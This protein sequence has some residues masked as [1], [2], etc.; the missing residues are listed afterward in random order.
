M[1]LVNGFFTVR[2]Q[3]LILWFAALEKLKRLLLMVAMIACI[4]YRPYYLFQ[5]PLCKLLVH[6]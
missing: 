1:S 5:L 3:F 4:I 2:N 6:W